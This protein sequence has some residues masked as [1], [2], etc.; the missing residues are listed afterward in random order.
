MGPRGQAAASLARL[1]SLPSAQ[2]GQCA[3]SIQGFRC[4]ELVTVRPSTGSLRVSSDE[5]RAVS[6]FCRTLWVLRQHTVLDQGKRG[7]QW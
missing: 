7:P 2:P 4:G 1:C 6:G 5:W 3:E